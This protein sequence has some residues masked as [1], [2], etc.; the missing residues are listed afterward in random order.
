MPSH[1]LVNDT[2]SRRL[3]RRR[4]LSALEI[5]RIDFF[6][7]DKFLEL[8]VTVRLGFQSLELVVSDPDV[9]RLPEFVATHKL[10]TLYDFVTDWTEMAVFEA[11]F[12][13]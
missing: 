4:I 11:A 3:L 6:D 9:L 2:L 8:D 12:G 10:M 5:N 7:R 13:V 1:R